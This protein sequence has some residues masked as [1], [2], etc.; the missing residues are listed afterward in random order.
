MNIKFILKNI[1]LTLAA[2][3]LLVI[4]Y[5][6][7]F[8]IS[9]L[10]LSLFEYGY[11]PKRIYPN[12]AKYAGIYGTQISSIFMIPV[13]YLFW[14]K[15]QFFTARLKWLILT[16]IPATIIYATI[17]ALWPF[18]IPMLLLWLP[19]AGIVWKIYDKLLNK[20]VAKTSH[21]QKI[22]FIKNFLA[23]SYIKSKGIARICITIGLCFLTISW[24]FVMF[25]INRID[26]FIEFV[27]VFIIYS[28]PYFIPFALYMFYI[29]TIHKI[30]L[31]IK[32][33]FY[34]DYKK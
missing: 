12:I 20:D 24:V 11:L 5:F 15:R 30:Y 18:Y 17:S 14:S 3:L 29:T 31:W 8:S 25:H 19:I 16:F 28:L 33:G 23:G 7:S 13:A 4:L 6:I 32:D 22:V 10:E 26:Y 34:Q 1:A 2:M 9:A 21:K 27:I